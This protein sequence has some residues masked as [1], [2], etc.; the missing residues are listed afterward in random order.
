MME[1]EVQIGPQPGPQTEFLRSEADIVVYGGAAGGGKT[2][3]LLLDPLRFVDKKGFGAVIFRRKTPDITTEGG[4]WDES[5]ELY[6]IAGGEPVQSP[7]HEWRFPAGTKVQFRHMEHVKNRLD[8]KGAQVPLIGFD[9]LEEFEA[10]QFW[11]LL[12]RSRSTCGVRPYIRATCNPPEEEDHWLY[13]LIDPW[14]EPD[15][16]D[17]PVAPGEL[18][19]FTRDGD[20][21]IW[22]D[23][24]WR[25]PDDQ[26]ARSFTFIPA[27]IYD[28]PALLERDPG[29]LSNLRAQPLGDRLRLLEGQWKVP[30][31]GKVFQ[32]DWFKI[33][34]EAPADLELIGRSW[35]LA[36]TEE[37]E[38]GDPD[39]SVGALVG[40]REGIWYVLDVVRGRMTP[41]AVDD[42]MDQTAALDGW[43]VPVLLQQDPGEAGKRGVQAHAQ[44]LTG[45]D[46]RWRR[47]TGDKPTRARPMAS[48]AEAKNLR[49]V[50]GEWNSPF[51][52]ECVVFPGRAHDDQV[53]AVSWAM[54]MLAFPEKKKS[55]DRSTPYVAGLDLWGS[56]SSG[57]E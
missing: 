5:F 29:Y 44:R 41:K 20:D 11:Y 35:D 42:L 25:D 33:V 32:R 22:V 26:P 34:Q 51:I 1:N 43:E 24:D 9:Q 47:P 23:E 8:W 39:Y 54:L 18:R 2:F 4:M 38:G 28:N 52:N 21:L 16:P 19:Y 36:A 53:D 57:R 10:K 14:I 48:A 12:T 17:Y 7:H 45:H 15:H 13:E 30:T 40:L 56:A 49:L 6:P 27:T 46:V 55:V 3:A 50:K 37:G 31:A